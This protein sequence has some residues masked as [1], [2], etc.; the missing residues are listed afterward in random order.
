MDNK[1]QQR[2]KYPGVYIDDKGNYF[3]QSE[4]GTDRITG[5]RIR[6]KGRRNEQGKPFSSASEANKY[7]TYLK[8][9]YHKVNSYANYKMTYEQ[10]MN[11]VYIPFYKCEVEES[12]FDVKKIY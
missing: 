9:E 5:K 12:T 2:T 10:F 8:R 1:T 4:F 3:Y 7:L 6:K 11:Q